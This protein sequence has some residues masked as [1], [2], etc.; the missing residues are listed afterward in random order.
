MP[1]SSITHNYTSTC[2]VYHIALWSD[3]ARSGVRSF[4]YPYPAR[5]RISKARLTL[6]PHDFKSWLPTLDQYYSPLEKQGWRLIMILAVAG[7]IRVYCNKRARG[8]GVLISVVVVGLLASISS[9]PISVF[10]LCLVKESF[11]WLVLEGWRDEWCLSFLVTWFHRSS[12]TIWATHNPSSWVVKLQN[13]RETWKNY[14]VETHCALSLYNYFIHTCINVA[15]SR[16]SYVIQIC[17]NI[18]SLPKDRLAH[19][20]QWITR[21]SVKLN[22][23]CSMPSLQ[24]NKEKMRLLLW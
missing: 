15:S 6:Q 21:Y 16:N 18:N 22:L 2:L 24:P 7:I 19:P 4:Q 3:L 20:G 10:P 1:P 14:H 17:I 23:K 11:A 8:G 13:K 5:R 12:A 9:T